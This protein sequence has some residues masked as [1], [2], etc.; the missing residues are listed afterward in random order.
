VQVVVGAWRETGDR[1]VRI[2]SR[3]DDG[4]DRAWTQHAEGILA[5]TQD[6]AAIEELDQWPPEGAKPIDVSDAYPQLATRGYEYGPA[7]QGLRSVWRRD[8]EVFVEAALPEQVKADAGRF[9]LHPAL[10]DAILHG[11][12]AGGI[13]AESELTRLPFALSFRS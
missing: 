1:R 7:F 6:P 8:D 10:L 4:A 13:L 3:T 5:P 2:Y 12:A 9:A 11:I